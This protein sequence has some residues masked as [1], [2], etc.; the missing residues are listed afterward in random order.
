MWFLH[1]NLTQ[2]HSYDSY[3]LKA[4]AGELSE[5][6]CQWIFSF[7][8]RNKEKPRICQMINGRKNENFQSQ[9][10]KIIK[11]KVNLICPSIILLL[12]V[13]KWAHVVVTASHRKAKVKHKKV[14][15]EFANRK[16]LFTWHP[17]WSTMQTHLVVC[18][19]DPCF[20]FTC[21]LGFI[22]VSNGI[23]S[24]VFWSMNL[25]SRLS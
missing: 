23:S 25:E 21:C 5:I 9:C 22:T 6:S 7:K 12:S 2:G 18:C 13:T 20:S 3:F 10:T 1:A 4:W 11:L 17:L 19:Y 8:K 15:F 16:V 14:V 24:L